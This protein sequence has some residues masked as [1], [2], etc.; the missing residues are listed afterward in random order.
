[1]RITKVLMKDRRKLNL[2]VLVILFIFVILFSMIFILSAFTKKPDWKYKTGSSI[3]SVSINQDGYVAVGSFNSYVYLFNRSRFD[4]IALPI[5]I[6]IFSIT[7]LILLIL[8]FKKYINDLY[9]IIDLILQRMRI[10]QLEM[11]KS[12]KSNRKIMGIFVIFLLLSFL[13]IES[14][15][16]NE[17]PITRDPKDQGSPAIYENI[18]VWTDSRNFIPDIYGYDLSPPPIPPFFYGILAVIVFIIFVLSI[19]KRRKRSYDDK[20]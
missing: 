2:F 11:R 8:E 20:T 16:N 10:L 1:M 14:S 7:V 17:F 9:N 13:Y 19:W 4:N 18:V 15:R 5:G 3:W 12:M 6:L